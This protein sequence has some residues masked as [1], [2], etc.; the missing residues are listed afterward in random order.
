MQDQPAPKKVEIPLFPRGKRIAVTTSWDDGLVFD[1]RI[2]EAFNAWGL[3]GTFNLNSRSLTRTGKPAPMEGK[4]HLDACEVADLY[5]GHEVAIHMATHPQPLLLT[6][7]QLAAEVLEDRQALEDLVGY[8]VR[9]MAYPFGRYN[10]A[11][12]DLLRAMGIVYSRTTET[13]PNC[14]PVDE[15]LAWPATMHMFAN[16]PAP[17]PQRWETYYGNPRQNGLFFVWG[18]SYEFD[19]A[20]C[21]DRLET[22]LAPL[23]GKPDVWYCTNIELWD[24]HAARQRLV[25]GANRRTAFNPS[26]LAVTVN[27]DGQL[28]DVPPGQVVALAPPASA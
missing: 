13:T 19:R 20:D 22:L 15:P 25:V 6:P 4:G 18:H 2:V 9:G 14:F 28:V 17:L 10:R 27:V 7:I 5:A 12:I 24:Y 21:W 3:K 26:A 1:R 11:F 8:P 23:A 16:S